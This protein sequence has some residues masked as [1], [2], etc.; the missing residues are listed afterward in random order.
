[1]SFAAAGSCV[2]DAAQAGNAS[3][4][5]AAHVEQTII[6]TGKP[7]SIAFATPAPG[8]VG[9]SAALTATASSGLPVTF[10]AGAGTCTVSGQTVSYPAAGSCV[11][12]A[13]QAGNASYAA[14]AH[15][16]QTVIVTGEPQSITFAA[17]APGAVGGSA[18]LTATASSGL[19][20]TF[21]V[22]AGTCTVSVRKLTETVSVS[23]VTYTAAG[24]CVIEASQPGNA[25]YAAAPQVQQTVKIGSASNLA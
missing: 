7:Q 18:T 17:L 10:R 15:V 6:V 20:V 5:A 14:A 8:T 11:I 9:G 16:Q 25:S 3:Y 4:A 12:D 19:P 2:I 1:V 22:S 13:A 21:T 24:S 23:T